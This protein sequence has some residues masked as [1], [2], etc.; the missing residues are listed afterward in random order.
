LVD[1]G[2]NRDQKQNATRWS[3]VIPPAS[4]FFKYSY[5]EP[6]TGTKRRKRMQSSDLGAS[7]KR[8]LGYR[9]SRRSAI[10]HGQLQAR[11]FRG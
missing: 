8:Q 4:F 9:S 2:K 3:G 11:C 6:E 5:P 7:A 10:P 1:I